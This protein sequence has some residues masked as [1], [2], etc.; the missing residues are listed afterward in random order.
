MPVLI[1][2]ERAGP[3]EGGPVLGLERPDH[4]RHDS[5]AGI[6]GQEYEGLYAE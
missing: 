1:R 5:S 4:S 3:P 6:R 2:L